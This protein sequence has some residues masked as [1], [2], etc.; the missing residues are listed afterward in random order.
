MLLHEEEAED[1]EEDEESVKIMFI[2]HAI[3]SSHFLH[4]VTF[5]PVLHLDV[6]RRQSETETESEN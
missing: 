3:F 2:P 4:A 1:E 5:V 6:P